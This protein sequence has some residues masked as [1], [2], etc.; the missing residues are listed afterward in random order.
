M[1]PSKTGPR[2]SEKN[3]GRALFYRLFCSARPRRPGTAGEASYLVG[4][5]TPAIEEPAGGEVVELSIH[6]E[7]QVRRDYLVWNIPQIAEARARIA[8][9]VAPPGSVCFDKVGAPFSLSFLK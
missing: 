5:G 8:S 2:P 3:T 1:E 7:L 6:L 4:P 9:A